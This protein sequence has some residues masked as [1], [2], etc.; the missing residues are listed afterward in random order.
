MGFYTVLLVIH[1]IIVLFL[2]IMVLVQ[3]SDS[4]G[5]GGLGGGGG[6]NQFLSGRTTANLMTRST[7]V[8]ATIFMIS[9]LALAVLASRMTEKSIIDSVPAEVTKPAEAV[10]Q[11]ATK[12]PK[13]VKKDTPT[14]PAV[15]KAD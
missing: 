13:P 4:D 14:A 2:I 10:K 11:D 5:M 12:T 7:A 15:P 3:R 9:S 8:L 6:G 1:T